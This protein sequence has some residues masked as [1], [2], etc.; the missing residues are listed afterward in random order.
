MVAETHVSSVTDFNALSRL[1]TRAGAN[2]PAAIRD[3]ARQFEAMFLQMMLKSMRDASNVLAESRDRTYEEMFDQQVA[4]ELAQRESLGMADLLL[5]QIDARSESAPDA[6]LSRLNNEV[7]VAAMPGTSGLSSRRRSNF[8]PADAGDFVSTIWP[9][10]RKSGESLGVDP[11][12]IVAQAALET[13]WGSQLIRDQS[14]VSGNNLFGI[15]ADERWSGER[16]AVSTLE[17]EGTRFVPQQAQF[18]AYATLAEGFDGYAQFLR[19]EPRYLQALQQ[20]ADPQAFARELQ[21]AGYATDPQYASKIEDILSSD[22][23][24]SLL[25]QAEAAK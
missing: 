7:G 24:E 18:R 16:I 13:G 22:R 9:L 8:V 2:D 1:K 6:G 14:G 15:K 25:E 10:A 3:A 19:T 11:R 20:G 17:Y 4:L 12:A 23:F 21:Q 5:R